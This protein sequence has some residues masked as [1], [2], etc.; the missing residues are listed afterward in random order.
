MDEKKL[1]AL[2]AWLADQTK[3]IHYGEVVIKVVLHAG[4]IRNVEKI[5]NEKQQFEGGGDE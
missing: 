3:K 4:K 5:I 2:T 1:N